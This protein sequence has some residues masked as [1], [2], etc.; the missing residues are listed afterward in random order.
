[1]FLLNHTY[2]HKYG[3]KYVHALKKRGASKM[4]IYIYIYIVEINIYT[5]A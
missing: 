1:M 2:I 5:D 3:Y 4:G